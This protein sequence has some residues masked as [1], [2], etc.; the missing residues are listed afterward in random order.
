M[1]SDF[2]AIINIITIYSLGPPTAKH[3]FPFLMPISTV[4]GIFGY[5]FRK[6]K[7]K[8]IIIR[9]TVLSLL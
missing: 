8:A 4:L 3:I 1:H 7:I 9:F 6:L 2:V 5:T